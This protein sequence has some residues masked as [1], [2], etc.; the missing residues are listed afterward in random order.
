MTRFGLVR[1]GYTLWNKEKRAQGHSNNPLDDEGM[2]Q[3]RAVAERLSKETW[4]LIVSSDLLRAQQTAQVIAET[5]GLQTIRYDRR[6]R[7]MYGGLIEGTTPEERLRKWGSNWSKLDLGKEK[8]EDGRARGTQCIHEWAS[9]YPG[10]NVLIVSHGAI[11]RHTLKGL[12]SEWDV[13]EALDNTSV[14]EIVKQDR[15]WACTL[16]NCTKHLHT[17]TGHDEKR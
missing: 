11:L 12:L 3:A 1:H 9:L 10:R 13:E 17:R 5:I 4:D 7:E 15:Q 6:L 8:P 2:L 14:T 16:Y